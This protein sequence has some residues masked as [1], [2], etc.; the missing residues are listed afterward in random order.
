MD[1]KTLK[2]KVADKLHIHVSRVVRLFTRTPSGRFDNLPETGPI[3]EEILK[4]HTILASIEAFF[5]GEL[6]RDGAKETEL[7]AA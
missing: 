4:K 7:S 1:V 5:P 6:T 2:K 3:P